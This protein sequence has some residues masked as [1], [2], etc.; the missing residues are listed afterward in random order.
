MRFRSEVLL[1]WGCYRRAAPAGRFRH[2][3]FPSRIMPCIAVSTRERWV[4]GFE[5]PI[6]RTGEPSDG[7]SVHWQRGVSLTLESAL[8]LEPVTNCAYCVIAYPSPFR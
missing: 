1:G 6:K 7:V 3:F 5:G 4:R 2:H 8:F